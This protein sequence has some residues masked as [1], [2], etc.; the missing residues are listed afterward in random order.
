MS[1]KRVYAR[2][3]R[4]MAIC[5]SPDFAGAHPGYFSFVRHVGDRHRIHLVPVL[6]HDGDEPSLPTAA[7]LDF[8]V[9]ELVGEHHRLLPRRGVAGQ[10]HSFGIFQGFS[11]VGDVK[12]VTRHKVL[13]L[14]TGLR[15][16]V[17]PVCA[18][19]APSRR[20]CEYAY[21][22]ERAVLPPSARPGRDDERRRL[23]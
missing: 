9:S 21:S 13:Q 16:T 18:N 5:G 20:G 19:S 10:V 1:H 12:V 7:R 2:L 6:I 15:Y 14:A 23:I 11:S 8:A 17:S 4:A 22:R 3:R